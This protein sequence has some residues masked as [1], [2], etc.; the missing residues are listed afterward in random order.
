MNEIVQK[1]F[2]IDQ[3]NLHSPKMSKNGNLPKYFKIVLNCFNC[4]QLILNGPSWSQIVPLFTQ[5]FTVTPS[6]LLME[7]GESRSSMSV[8]WHLRAPESQS[9]GACR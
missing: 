2:K 3:N 7:D 4:Y 1:W 9:L 6:G 8:P 5:V